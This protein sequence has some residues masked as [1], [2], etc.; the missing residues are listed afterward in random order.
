MCWVLDPWPDPLSHYCRG[1]SLIL[2]RAYYCKIAWDWYN[3]FPDLANILV[4]L[5]TYD[6]ASCIEFVTDPDWIF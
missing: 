1:G 5:L 3:K 2:A 4:D 6:N